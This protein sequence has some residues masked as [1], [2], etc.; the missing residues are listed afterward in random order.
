[1][2][3]AFLLIGGNMGDRKD[4]LAK[5]RQ[6]LSGACGHLTS[7]SSI[8]ETAA[9]GI[10]DQEPF[11][12]QALKLES[13]FKPDQLLTCILKI[14]EDMGRKRSAKFGPR[15]IDI[16]ILLFNNEIIEQPGLRIPHPEMQNRKFALAPLNEIASQI[17]HPV[18]HKTI[19]QLLNECTD[20]LNVKKLKM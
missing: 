18:L 5:A 19:H 14:E 4:F 2:N 17:I 20:P 16:D 7:Y 10:M 9:W 8:Y 11:L 15:V 12:N 13:D 1:M 6:A 3:E